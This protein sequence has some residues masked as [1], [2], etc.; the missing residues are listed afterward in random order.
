MLQAAEDGIKYREGIDD[1]VIDRETWSALESEVEA[2][3][4]KLRAGFPAWLEPLLIRGTI[5]ITL[6]RRVYLGRELLRAASADVAAIVAHELAHVRQFAR[7]GPARFAW[8]YL[9]DYARN[10]R[11]G[12]SAYDAYVAIPFEVEARLAENRIRSTT[13]H[14]ARVPPA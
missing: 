11:R 5:A 14:G 1:I 3:G 10:R 13:A 6:G 9:R 12:M 8:R 4:G 7:V 2:A